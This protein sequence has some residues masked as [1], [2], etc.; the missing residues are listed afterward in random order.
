M[1]IVK[2]PAAIETSPTVERYSYP[3]FVTPI[4]GDRQRALRLINDGPAGPE[5]QS[6]RTE[7]MRDYREAMKADPTYFEPALAWGWPQSTRRI[8]RLPW[9]RSDRP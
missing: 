5:H 2:T 9:M 4:P 7:A 3:L 6:R 8:T 1:R